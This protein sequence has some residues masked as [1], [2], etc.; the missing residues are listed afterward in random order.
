MAGFVPMGPITTPASLGSS[1]PLTTVPP[2]RKKSSASLEESLMTATQATSVQ[3]E[4]THQPL[5]TDPKPTHAPR[6]TI[7][8]LVCQSHRYV[9]TACLLSSK[10]PFRWKS[11]SIASQGTTVSMALSKLKCAQ[12]E[13]T[14][15]SASKSRSNVLLLA[16]T[17]S[18]WEK[19]LLTA[20]CA[21]KAFT[22]MM[23]GWPT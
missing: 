5:I 19:T 16:T 1:R 11:A 7:V 13:T 3:Q 17:R 9:L 20:S 22:V 15:P 6:A 18:R 14:A 21:K 12:S 2:A 8:V 10:A 23:K 4:L